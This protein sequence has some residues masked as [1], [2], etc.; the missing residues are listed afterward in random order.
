MI[1]AGGEGRPA[2]DDNPAQ[3]RAGQGHIT[4]CICVDPISLDEYRTARCWSDPFGITVAAHAACLAR[5]GE[6]ELG[7]TS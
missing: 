4:C 1:S 5:V 2:R 6:H 7:I 3:S